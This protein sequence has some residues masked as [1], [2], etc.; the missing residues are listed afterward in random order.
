[1]TGEARRRW[2]NVRDA[3]IVGFALLMAGLEISLWGARPSV[4]TF[5]TGL[6]FS[7]VVIRADDAR[8][9]R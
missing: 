8:R 5:C 4:L 9:G 6:L 2:S 1:M 3:A 7:P